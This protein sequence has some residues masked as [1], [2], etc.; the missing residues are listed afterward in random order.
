MIWAGLLAV[1][2]PNLRGQRHN[3]DKAL[4]HLL[5]SAALRIADDDL[6]PVA[7]VS[8]DRNV[9]MRVNSPEGPGVGAKSN[10]KSDK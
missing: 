5:I 7:R 9:C 1:V 3:N 6:D 4:R 8:F 2:L 10:P